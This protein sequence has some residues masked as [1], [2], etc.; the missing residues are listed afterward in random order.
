MQADLHAARYPRT[1]SLP[2]GA[3]HGRL[4]IAVHNAGIL[5][6]PGVVAELDEDAW[7][8][9]RARTRTGV[10]WLAYPEFGF[11]VGPGLV[12]DGGATA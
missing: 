1:H 6:E 2:V 8:A 4:D 11:V 10:L 3:K 9:V 12:L 7:A 5:G